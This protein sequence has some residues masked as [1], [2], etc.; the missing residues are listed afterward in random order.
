MKQ[1]SVVIM[2]CILDEN[3]M[4]S[5]ISLKNKLKPNQDM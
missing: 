1:Y 2:F 5:L 3:L 4:D